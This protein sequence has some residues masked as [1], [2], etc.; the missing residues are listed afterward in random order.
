[1]ECAVA[2][3]EVDVDRPSATRSNGPVTEETRARIC[4]SVG[5]RPLD[6]TTSNPAI[7]HIKPR[8]SF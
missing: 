8:Y 5:I 6:S 2:D 1:M 3:G 4:R 7:D